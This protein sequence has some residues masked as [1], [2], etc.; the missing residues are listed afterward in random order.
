MDTTVKHTRATS[1]VVSLADR[2]QQRSSQQQALGPA[3]SPLE[4]SLLN[5]VNALTVEV[6]DARR[7]I[8]ALSNTV[9]KLLRLLKA[10]GPK[11]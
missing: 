6:I 1:N 8:E 4:A 10:K 2:R 7:E 11:T 9:Q 3:P 5:K